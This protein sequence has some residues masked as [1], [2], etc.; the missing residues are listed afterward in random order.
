MKK[1]GILSSA[2]HD[3]FQYLH[4]N[5][6][7]RTSQCFYGNNAIYEIPKP[8]VPTVLSGSKTG[9]IKINTIV[10]VCIRVGVVFCC[11]SFYIYF[12]V[13]ESNKNKS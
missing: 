3:A 8:T 12:H 9:K 4:Y 5:F 7:V 13:L 11:Y 1:N 6:P 2:I 10:N